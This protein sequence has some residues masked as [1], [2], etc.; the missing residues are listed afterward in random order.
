LHEDW[1]GDVPQEAFSEENLN[2]QLSDLRSRSGSERIVTASRYSSIGYDEPRQS[3][4]T[5]SKQDKKKSSEI[6]LKTR[7]HYLQILESLGV[8]PDMIELIDN[9]I[10]VIK[11][12]VA[13]LQNSENLRLYKLLVLGKYPIASKEQ[14]NVRYFVEGVTTRLDPQ[15]LLTALQQMHNAQTQTTTRFPDSLEGAQLVIDLRDDL[16]K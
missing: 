2:T 15:E 3:A 12:L 8:P 5:S 10:E 16:I 14:E 13:W 9:D 7:G 6:I 1:I 11:P 4:N